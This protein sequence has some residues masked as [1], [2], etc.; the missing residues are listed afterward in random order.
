MPASIPYSFPDSKG[1]RGYPAPALPTTYHLSEEE[2]SAGRGSDLQGWPQSLPRAI[3]APRQAAEAC[4]G[5]PFPSLGLMEGRQ[6]KGPQQQA[7]TMGLARQG[8]P[9]GCSYQPETRL[10]E[11]RKGNSGRGRDKEGSRAQH[12]GLPQGWDFAPTWP[13][14]CSH[15]P[16]K[17]LLMFI[18]LV[19]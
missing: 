19:R 4:K 18:F 12:N 2:R 11:G 5:L 17:Y 7:S 13:P 10:Q 15:S 6:E 9:W 16:C 3:G 14:V 1:R 8:G